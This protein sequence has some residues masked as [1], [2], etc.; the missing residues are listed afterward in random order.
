MSNK[1]VLFNSSISLQNELL[2]IISNDDSPVQPKHEEA[3]TDI[4]TEILEQQTSD[5]P[6]EQ[7][8]RQPDAEALRPK[9]E[10]DDDRVLTAQ[11]IIYRALLNGDETIYEDYQDGNMAG[12]N[13]AENM[14]NN[15]LT[16][17]NKDKPLE[18]SPPESKS[19]LFD[20]IHE[21]KQPEAVL[22]GGNKPT[23]F[24]EHKHVTF[25]EKLNHYKSVRAMMD[26]LSSES[27]EG[28]S[29]NNS[30]DEYVIQIPK[31]IT[32]I[33]NP[34][35][36]P[37]SVK[38]SEETNDS[39]PVVNAGPL[40]TPPVVPGSETPG[41]QIITDDS[42]IN[43]EGTLP[44]NE[45]L[46]LHPDDVAANNSNDTESN[47]IRSNNAKRSSIPSGFTPI[48]KNN[49]SSMSKASKREESSSSSDAEALS[50]SSSSSADE[51]VF[52]N[53]PHPIETSSDKRHN[54]KYIR[55]INQ[56]K[57]PMPKDKYHIIGGSAIR[58]KTV[59]VINAFPYI[60]KATPDNA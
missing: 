26:E 46:I 16:G 40:E 38:T 59:T 31:G 15:I 17:G 33:E 45:Y 42:D 27:S 55:I 32:V 4:F 37:S 7:T 12:G 35:E 44:P 20:E 1:D 60:I 29:A 58:P 34:T 22:A 52:P 11:E 47:P 41:Y 56:F 21:G 23:T 9:H 51:F 49:I 25:A 5:K 13:S 30:D 6:P 39:E 10:S 24:A 3:P 8:K 53:D 36:V 43:T 50:D 57:N 2:K 48:N 19:D 28:S 54:A 18:N 14:I